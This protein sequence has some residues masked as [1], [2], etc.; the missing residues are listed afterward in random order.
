MLEPFDLLSTNIDDIEW[1]SIF[2]GWSG[3]LVA[4]L[5]CCTRRY[6][7]LLPQLSIGGRAARWTP[8]R[9]NAA[10]SHE[11]WSWQSA[12][13]TTVTPSARSAPRVGVA[14]Q[15]GGGQPPHRG[16][17]QVPRLFERSVRSFEERIRHQSSVTN[18]RLVAKYYNIRRI[19]HI[20]KCTP[21]FGNIKHSRMLTTNTFSVNK[22][23]FNEKCKLS[24]F[25]M[26]FAHHWPI[27]L[28]ILQ[29]FPFRFVGQQNIY[30]C[31]TIRDKQLLITV[32]SAVHIQQ[33]V[34]MFVDF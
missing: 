16:G 27:M 21:K 32:I 8:I 12:P 18:F 20:V 31:W 4:L 25:I 10:R 5:Q 13:A 22:L 2:S 17:R 6:H 24:T 34:V 30:R 7:Q 11:T 29:G 15:T 1:V 19:H 28:H 14:R 33:R 3:W 9:G 23:A 26:N